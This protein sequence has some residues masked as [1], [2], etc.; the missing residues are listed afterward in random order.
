VV[1]SFALES[2]FGDWL[3]LPEVTSDA[4]VEITFPRRVPNSSVS[5]FFFLQVSSRFLV[6]Y[7]DSCLFGP[8]K[9]INVKSRLACSDL[10]TQPF[11]PRKSTIVSKA[12]TSEKTS[13]A[14]VDWLVFF[15][16]VDGAPSLHEVNIAGEKN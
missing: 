11:Q 4:S 14:E 9:S 8:S 15:F 1:E 3:V 13:V 6:L 10:L 7:Q 16:K 12:E 2:V 5:V